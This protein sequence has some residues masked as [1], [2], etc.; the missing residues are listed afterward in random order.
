MYN[1]WQ[2]DAARQKLCFHVHKPPEEDWPKGL[3][4]FVRAFFKEEGTTKKQY[5]S[6]AKQGG[7]YQI[8]ASWVKGYLVI[9]SIEAVDQ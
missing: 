7:R 4:G 3:A 8:K 2:P 1:Q 9:D 5:Q 6:M